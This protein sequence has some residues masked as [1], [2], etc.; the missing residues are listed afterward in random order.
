MESSKLSIYSALAANLL[1]AVTKFAAGSI[2]NSAAM[3]SEGIHSLVDTANEMLLLFGLYRSKKKPDA[4]H[5]FGYGKELYFWSFIVAILM[6]GLGGGVSIY[7]GIIHIITPEKLENATVSYLVLALSMLFD[8]TSLLI[9]LRQ[10][11]RVRGGT[12]FW[13]AVVKS[14]NPSN[15]LVVFEDGADVL[16]LLA[17]GICIYL[18]HHYREPRLDGVASIMVGL[19]LVA[20][21]AILARESRSLLMGEGIAPE[22]AQ[23]ITGLLQAD[24]DVSKVIHILS[25]YQ[26]PDEVLLILVIEFRPGLSTAQI[27]QAITR[28]RTGVKQQFEPIRY[29]LIQPETAENEGFWENR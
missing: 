15:F 25:T 3:I 24:P 21:S 1:I 26:S 2:S 29:I 11:N 13:E 12:P 20:A 6:F 23:T 14:K 16:G 9:S 17:A 18:A 27:N 10:F 8:G 7:Q 4:R 5:P 28:L 22:T 19:I